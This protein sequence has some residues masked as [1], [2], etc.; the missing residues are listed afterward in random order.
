MQHERR[1]RGKRGQGERERAAERQPDGDRH[2][3]E[4][5]PLDPF[6]RQERHVDQQDD[7]ERERDR[8]GGALHRGRDLGGDLVARGDASGGDADERELEHDDRA[9]DQ[10]AEVDGAQRHQVSR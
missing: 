3:L 2:R 4:H 6:Q 8:P 9:V 1:Q 5:P 7:R 10:Q